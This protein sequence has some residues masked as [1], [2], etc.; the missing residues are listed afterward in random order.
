MHVPKTSGTAMLDAIGRHIRPGRKFYAQDR[1][2]FGRFD[3]FDEFQQPVRGMIHTDPAMLPPRAELIAGHMACST[4]L[5]AGRDN[6]VTLLRE[7]GMRLLSHWIFWRNHGD[8]ELAQFG[9]WADR[10]R[11]AREPLAGF[12]SDPALA[13]QTDNLATRM[14]L[15]PHRLIP[16]EGFIDPRSDAALIE[17]ALQRL[18][19]FAF[20]DLVENPAM[21]A[22]LQSWLG[23]PIEYARSNETLPMHPDR[24][25]VL[26]AEMTA[27]ARLSMAARCRLDAL[28]W[29]HLANRCVGAGAVAALRQRTVEGGMRRFAL[30]LSGAGPGA[31]ARQAAA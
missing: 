3:G 9:S 16:D 21:P 7:P 28:L 6:L 24:R 27:Q 26:S 15:W 18:D 17:A 22:S 2:L 11:A 5:A 30:L 20:A 14:L 23:R 10:V 19:A 29:T 13:C 31:D 25:T 12:L 4:L 1:V 8:D